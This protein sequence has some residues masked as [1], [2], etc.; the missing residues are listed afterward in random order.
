M[1]KWDAALYGEKVLKKSSLDQMWTA[2]MLNNGETFPYGFGW[3]PY[4]AQGHRII[5]HGGGWQ[6]FSSFIGR[7]VDDKLT[8]VVFANLATAKTGTIMNGVAAIYGA[9]P[10][11]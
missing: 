7:Y 8:I 3:F 6:G 5:H 11:K 1:A 10:L 4:E 2:V 9:P